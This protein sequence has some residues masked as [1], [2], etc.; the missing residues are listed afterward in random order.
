M[1][2]HSMIS[3]RDRRALRFGAI[4]AIPAVLYVAAFKPYVASLN[5]INAAVD[6][7]RDLLDRERALVAAAP[8]LPGEIARARTA[9]ATEQHRVYDARDLVA[10]TSALSRDVNAALRDAGVA[11]QRLDARDPIRRGEGLHELTIDLRAEGDLEGVLTALAS[12]E[13]AKKL[14]RVTRLAVERGGSATP[15]AAEILAVTATIHGYAR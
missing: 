12:L 9:L 14:I 3:L 11:P 5:S 15:N 7:Q 1:A 4:L 6:T 13:T 8:A 2:A 10:A